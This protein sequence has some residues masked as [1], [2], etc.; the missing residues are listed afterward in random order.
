MHHDP[1]L[2]RQAGETATENKLRALLKRWRWFGA[3]VVLPSLLGTVYFG[4]VAADIYVSVSS[5]VIKAPDKQSASSVSIGSILQGTGLGSGQEQSSE[6]IGYLHSRDALADLSQKVEVREA[7]SSA[8]ADVFSGFPRLWAT[9]SFEDLYAFYLGKVSAMP[10]PA[11]GLT[12]LK[13][14]AFT[15]Q[16]AQAINLGLLEL[17]EDLVNQLNERVNAQ[18]IA[19]AEERVDE[20][21]KRV[22]DA[23]ISLSGY[24][25]T[26]RILDPQQEGMGVMAASNELISQETALR[27]QLSQLQRTAPNHPSIPAIR[28]RIAAT[29]QQIDS[30]TSRAVGT[31]DGLASRLSEYENLLVEQEFATQL[32]TVANS[33]FEQAR[34]EAEQ[35]QYYLERVVEPNLPDAPILPNRLKSILAVIFASLCVYL[36]GWMLAVGIREHAP[37]S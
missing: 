32:L 11:S 34:V 20:A 29:R 18:A 19:D 31:S 2:Q 24:R 23:R 14:E 7:F 15:P 33:S 27:A 37:E 3:F 21:Q 10:D 6:I 25:N 36:V 8:E 1:D 4:F 28:E 16:E 35:Q 13:V 30:Q 17:S 26:A 22:R 9:G 5:F 12:Q